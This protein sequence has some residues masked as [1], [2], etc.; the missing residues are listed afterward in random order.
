LGQSLS[1]LPLEDRARLYRQFAADAI[2]R[3]E[4]SARQELRAGH[5]SMAA[6]WHALALEVEDSLGLFND[7]FVSTES[8]GGRLLHSAG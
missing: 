2:R 4:Q 1:S 7:S 8:A 3:S 5:L 6:G